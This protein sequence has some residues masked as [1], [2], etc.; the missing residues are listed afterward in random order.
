MPGRRHLLAAATTLLAAPAMAQ[1]IAGGR[2][3]RLIVPFPPGGAVDLL[4]RLLAERL[5]PAIGQNVIVENR[6]GAGGNIG[7]DAVAK[8]APDGTTLGLLGVS[9]LCAAPFL[10]RSLPFDTRKDFTPIA[11]I[12]TG[13]VLCV[14]NAD[15][16]RKNGWR[17]FASLIA[18]AKAHPGEVRMGSSGTG[19]TSHFT[20]AAVNR[21]AG[22]EITHVPYRGGGPAISDLLAGTIDMMFDVMPALMPHVQSGKFLPLA[23]SS[24]DRLAILPEVPGMKDLAA[25]GL[26]ELDIQS[27][28]AVMAPAGLPAPIAAQLAAALKAV[29]ADPAFVERLR[30]LG[31]SVRTTDSP[32]ALAALIQAETPRWRQLVEISGAQLD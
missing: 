21:F 30:P 19:T 5:A 31:Y 18:W 12:V 24:A 1:P 16:A 7:A 20:I 25:F 26:G 15:T 22:V 32:E 10:Y 14:V 8:A 2:P 17:D 29:A 28:N 11:A 6:G 3:I 9:T 27:W 23:V 13:A 4:G